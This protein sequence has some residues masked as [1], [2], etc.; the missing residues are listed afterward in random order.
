MSYKSWG[1]G[2]TGC[3]LICVAQWCLQWRA[4]TLKSVVIAESGDVFTLVTTKR[5]QR[6]EIWRWSKNLA[7]HEVIVNEAPFSTRMI[8]SRDGSLL[9]IPDKTLLTCYKTGTGE[10]WTWRSPDSFDWLSAQVF[11]T[12]AGRFVVGIRQR[13]GRTR[14]V[15]VDSNDGKTHSTNS[16]NE[17]VVELQSR[18]DQLRC[19][20]DWSD[21]IELPFDGSRNT[22]AQLLP[23]FPSAP[24]EAAPVEAGWLIH[25][26]QEAK[27]GPVFLSS[28]NSSTLAQGREHFPRGSFSLVLKNRKT[29]EQL[30]SAS[31][32]LSL[33]AIK[34]LIAALSV[35]AALWVLLLSMHGASSRHPFRVFTDT[36]VGLGL[37]LLICT[38]FIG[39][40]RREGNP[41]GLAVLAALI[42]PAFLSFIFC[43]SV[44]GDRH[45]HTWGIVF[46]ACAIPLI[47]PAIILA[48]IM[49][50][51]NV[52]I[53]SDLPLF[54]SAFDRGA[55]R[56]PFW[57][58]RVQATSEFDRRMFRFGILEMMLATAAIAFFIAIGRHTFFMPVYAPLAAMLFLIAAC[59]TRFQ[60][61]AAIVAI[62]SVSVMVFFGMQSNVEGVANPLPVAIGAVLF[63]FCYPAIYGLSLGKQ[64]WS[65]EQ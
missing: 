54:R 55:L 11:F 52:R 58:P 39:I 9:V 1:L 42:L 10:S 4:L 43:F 32:G 2:I 46:V 27:A 49:K 22:K 48:L 31:L 29:S 38:S 37:V 41:A 21:V 36:L 53:Q 51:M 20:T 8:A 5:P 16:L 3:L 33:P 18:G 14:I 15:V 24:V 12:D 47:L 62:G 50:R 44:E 30:A 7:S 60:A 19:V 28:T 59:L 17:H 13:P 61:H 6:R 64:R 63:C 56:L 65:P 34:E 40:D 45:L 57:E 35:A 23:L 26:I 25:E